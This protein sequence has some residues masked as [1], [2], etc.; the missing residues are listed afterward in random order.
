MVVTL[1][2]V[3]RASSSALQ[4]MGPGARGHAAQFDWSLTVVDVTLLGHASILFDIAIRPARAVGW[5]IR[6]GRRLRRNR[7]GRIFGRDWRFLP[8]LPLG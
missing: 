1:R 8:L 4:G 3:S 7:S 5:R 6:G 2:A